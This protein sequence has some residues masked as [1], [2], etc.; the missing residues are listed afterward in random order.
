[1]GNALLVVDMLVGF[2]VEGHNLYCGDES[3]A[4]IPN[5]CS[6]IEDHQS[7]GD[8]V[9]FIC[10]SHELD[11][12]EFEMF[13][14]HCVKGTEESML[15]PELRLYEGELIY[16][17]RYSGFFKTDLDQKLADIAPDLITI[18]GVC[19]DICVMHTA[20]D[21]RN[22]D[23]KVKVPGNA[24]ASFDLNAHETALDHLEKILGATVIRSN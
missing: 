9:I 24:V 8:S 20:A 13:P 22:R 6:L 14:V 4:I 16:K 15:I 3:R 18:C 1:M 23:Y 12:L 21:A 19:T 11:D 2:M 5:I 7:R 17:T 10:D